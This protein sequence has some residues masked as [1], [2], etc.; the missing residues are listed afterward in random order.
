MLFD[1]LLAQ[2]QEQ[3]KKILGDDAT[4]P[5]EKV[6]VTALEKKYVDQGKEFQ[7][8]AEDLKDQLEKLDD[9]LDAAKNGVKRL[10]AAYQTADFGLDEKKDAKKVGQG[11]QLFSAF[12]AKVLSEYADYEK[13][14]DELQKHLIQLNKYKGPGK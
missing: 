13:T 2:K 5:D 9:A 11:R 8:G 1:K 12:F 6:D 7:K 3:A 10:A 14:V 4:M